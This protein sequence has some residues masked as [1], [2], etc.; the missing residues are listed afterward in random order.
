MSNATDEIVR[1]YLNDV[2]HLLQHADAPS[3][4]I[5]APTELERT[6][7]ALRALLAG[8]SPAGHGRCPRCTPRWAWCRRG[9]PCRAWQIA[10]Q[11]LVT[12]APTHPTGPVL[13]VGGPR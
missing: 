2:S 6:I 13:A 12:A 7:Q 11:Y 8:H 9:L 3:V 10:H 5:L 4:A 1:D